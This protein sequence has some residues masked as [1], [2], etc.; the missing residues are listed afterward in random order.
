MKSVALR[1]GLATVLSAVST[2]AAL[3]QTYSTCSWW[4]P[5]TCTSSGSGSTGGSTSGSGSTTASVP[6][7]DASTGLIALVAVLAVVALTWE[8]RRR[9]NRA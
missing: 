2:G 5:W 1:F 4:R 3:A 8:R 6:E 9:A 7:I